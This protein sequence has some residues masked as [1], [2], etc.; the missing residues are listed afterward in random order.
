MEGVGLT[1]GSVPENISTKRLDFSHVDVNQAF[2]YL[3][4]LGSGGTSISELA[5]DEVI[6]MT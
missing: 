4:F 1:R 3:W 6:V 2:L 5:D